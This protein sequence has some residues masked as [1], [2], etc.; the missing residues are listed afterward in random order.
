MT[1]SNVTRPGALSSAQMTQQLASFPT[2]QSPAEAPAKRFEAEASA[3]WPHSDDL[4]SRRWRGRN[5]RRA[6]P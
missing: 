4:A 6:I 3:L 2:Y 5:A 1:Q